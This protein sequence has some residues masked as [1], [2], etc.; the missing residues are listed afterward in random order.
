LTRSER[1]LRKSL[2]ATSSCWRTCC[3]CETR[4]LPRRNLFNAEIRP[5]LTEIPIGEQGIA[6]DRFEF[7]ACLPTTRVWG[8][9]VVGVLFVE[10]ST[11]IVSG[12]A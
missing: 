3:G 11:K 5:N 7:D 6:F 12:Y 8:V 10:R 4:R 1:A 9:A 2:P